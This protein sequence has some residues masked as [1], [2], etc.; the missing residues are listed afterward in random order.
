MLLKTVINFA[1]AEYRGNLSI[2]SIHDVCHCLWP[3]LES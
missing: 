2:L 1:V 3:L